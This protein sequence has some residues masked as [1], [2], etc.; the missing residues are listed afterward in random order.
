MNILKYMNDP[1]KYALAKIINT[2]GTRNITD[3]ETQAFMLR[4]TRGTEDFEWVRERIMEVRNEWLT[5][6]TLQQRKWQTNVS[7]RPQR[8]KH[9]DSWAGRESVV[10]GG[11][12]TD[13]LPTPGSP[14]RR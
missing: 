6:L 12:Y 5:W 2:C 13:Y 7:R 3:L 10:R 8:T 14:A 1:H 4:S 9:H 11:H